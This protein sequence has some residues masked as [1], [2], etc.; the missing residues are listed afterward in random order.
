M[1]RQEMIAAAHKCLL[2]GPS[3]L[4]RHNPV[5]RRAEREGVV[6]NC[7]GA[8]G[9][10][11]NKV[12]VVGPSPSLPRILELAAGFFG[13]DSGG[14]GIVVEADAGHTVEAELRAAGW[15]VFEDEPALVF[16][17]IPPAPPLPAGLVVKP[18]CDNEG[19]REL[20]RVVADGFGAPTAEGGTE[21]SPDAF[22]SL[23]PSTA[24]ALDPE[25]ALLLGYL[26]GKPVS[27]ALLFT[28]GSIAGITGVTTIPAYRRRGLATALTWEAL[29]AGA[30]R[31][32]TCATLAAL[33]PSYDL[34]RKMGFVHVCNHRAY[35]AP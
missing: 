34:Y 9:P 15:Q 22:D 6:L 16:P 13:A 24:C 26:D 14:F 1:N 3:P 7:W 12:A 32:C 4:L 18:V 31:G 17:C 11:L 2:L 5:G 29:R 25:V 10:D 35:R 30:V 28:V 33:G 21:L 23:A 8:F 27:S 19:R 20:V